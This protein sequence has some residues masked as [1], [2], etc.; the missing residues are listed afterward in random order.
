[1]TAI[2]EYFDFSQLALAAYADLDTSLND[3]SRR[4]DL[5][6]ALESAAFSSS[7]ATQFAP[8]YT[9]LDQEP[10]DPASGF[11]ATIFS[12]GQGAQEE[13]IL[14]IRIDQWGQSRL[15]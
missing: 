11:S 2:Q 7:Q 9:I 15:I 5:L 6:D 3:P 1:M 10:N 4:T 8:K 12:R 13:F 14:A